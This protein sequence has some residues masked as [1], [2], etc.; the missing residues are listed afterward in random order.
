MMLER[1]RRS[2]FEKHLGQ[3]FTLALEDAELPLRLLEASP[4]GQAS[5]NLERAPFALLFR[6]P[7][8]RPLNQGMFEFRHP[9]FGGMT[10]FLVP[11][12]PDA[13]GLCY[14]VVFN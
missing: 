13:E 2:D 11:I 10:L 3:E 7:K 12:G 6:G 8:E 9:E 4:M 1:L 14:E 5:G